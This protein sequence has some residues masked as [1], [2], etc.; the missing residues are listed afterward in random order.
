VNKTN[1]NSD[2]TYI[3][4]CEMSEEDVAGRVKIKMSSHFIHP[5][6]G[7]WNKNGITWLEEYTQDNIK[8]AIGM[9]Y[10]VSWA[11]EENQI[12]SGHGEMS[13]DEDG[14]VKFEGVV[15]GSV[16]DAYICDVEIDG[17]IKKVM[18]TEGYINSQRYN[19][20]VKWLKE[21]IENGKVYGSI[22]INGKGKAKNIVY[23][24]GNKNSDGSMLDGRIP[25][26]FDFSGLAI[27]S[28]LENQADDDSIV[29]EVNSKQND[30]DINKSNDDKT[31]KEDDI[32]G[33]E[34]TKTSIELNELNITDLATLVENGF[35][36]KF[37]KE[38]S[39]SDDGYQYYYI[40]KFY[41]TSATFVM[42]SYHC[43]GEYYGSSYTVENSKVIIGSIVKVTEGWTPVDGEE[44]V[45][46]NNT[47]INIL[48]NQTKEESKKM[49]EK[50]V[51]ELN[52]K[53][54]DKINEI[55][56]LNKSLEEKATEINTL[57]QSLEEKQVEINTLTEKTQDLDSKVVELNTTIVEVNKLLESE[58]AE[59][60]S[61]NVE[62][63]SFREAK[64]KT[65]SE[66]K[67]AEVNSYFET[68]ITKNGFEE[69]EVNSLKTFVEAIDLDGLK[70]AE[71]ELCAKK[72]KEMI[73]NNDT[74]DVEVNSTN[75]M[76][77]SIKEKEMKKV[78]GS[79]PSFFN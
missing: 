1:I 4:I 49:D 8:S 72:F 46:V 68:E 17:Q 36:T 42:K 23:L 47:L 63:N 70:K 15:V 2:N 13:F 54:E 71:A 67:I 62:V 39:D 20:F 69:S 41:P 55:N 21:E 33:D 64:I 44:S 30:L 48:N 58:K 7:K 11:D 22:E 29:F 45:E 16:L 9:N 26:I 74:T 76:F 32:L 34:N 25:T 52:Q 66:A 61:L 53:I 60:E 65:E 40:H 6:V 14:N 18:M 5:E 10:V 28:N 50:I 35:N 79:I 59:K 57:T 73:A 37:N 77:I 78:P 3:E 31:G 27:L 24:D 75:E 38:N 12:P 19:L 56:S 51:L 43:V